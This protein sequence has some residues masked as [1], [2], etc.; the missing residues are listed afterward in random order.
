MN[1]S[2]CFFL[3]LSCE[4]TESLRHADHHRAGLAVIREGIAEAAGLGGAAR[5]VVLRDRNRAP[6][7]CRC[8]SDK[9]DAARCRRWAS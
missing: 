2:P 1:G 3:N 5:R 7:S 4:A 9:R 6:P 8:S